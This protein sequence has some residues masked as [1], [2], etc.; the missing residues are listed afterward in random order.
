MKNPFANLFLS[1]EVREALE[2]ARASIE[3]AY[4]AKKTIDSI[5]VT[6]RLANMFWKKAE[7]VAS[8]LK[9]DYYTD[10]LIGKVLKE[11]EEKAKEEAQEEA[12]AV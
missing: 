2:Q 7:N 6:E 8:V 10:L 9:E 11:K 1:R 5:Y 3:S 4:E 12:S